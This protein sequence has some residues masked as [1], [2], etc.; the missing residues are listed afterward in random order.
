LSPTPDAGY[1]RPAA[2]EPP[3]AVVP[4]PRFL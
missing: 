4:P 1:H 3:G 2:P